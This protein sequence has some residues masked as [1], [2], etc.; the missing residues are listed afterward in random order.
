[1]GVP[2]ERGTLGHSDMQDICP[3]SEEADV[4]PGSCASAS[5]SGQHVLMVASS[6][7]LH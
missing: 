4:L 5:S 6:G 1:V 7:P 2:G 3:D